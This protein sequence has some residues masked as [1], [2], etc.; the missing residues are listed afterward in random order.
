MNHKRVRIIIQGR[1]QGVFFRAYTKEEA[2]ARALVGWVRNL[3]D[4]SV[5][6]LVQGEPEKVDQMITWFHK[7]SPMANVTD[8]Q[9]YEEEA[10]SPFPDF[11]IR[12]S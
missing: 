11:T 7:G 1:V 2:E 9:I 5:E 10:V 6:A 12:Y 3:P 8:V 4:G